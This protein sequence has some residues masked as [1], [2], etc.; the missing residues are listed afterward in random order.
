MAVE[1]NIVNEFASVLYAVLSIS[2]L[3][4][5]LTSTLNSLKRCFIV[6]W[7]LLVFFL[8]FLKDKESIV[9]FCF[10]PKTGSEHFLEKGT[11]S[12][13]NRSMYRVILQKKGGRGM[14][15]HE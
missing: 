5:A 13:I 11:S 14:G 4:H 2:S 3:T 9:V 7:F 15:W 6:H 8:Y 10:F 12:E 1:T